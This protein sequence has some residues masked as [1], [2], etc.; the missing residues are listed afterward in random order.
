MPRYCYRNMP[1][2]WRDCEQWPVADLTNAGEAAIERFQRM[3]RGLR[4]YLQKGQLRLAATEAGCSS[5]VL[6]DVL[7]RCLLVGEDMKPIG[8]IGAVEGVRL[9]PYTRKKPTEGADPRGKS[10]SFEQFLMDN[11]K[12]KELLH[13]LIESG[14]VD[15]GPKSS[16]PTRRGVA[17]RF[18][19]KCFALGMTENDY[20]FNTKDRGRRSIERYVARRIAEDA[21]TTS[22]WLGADAA[23]K[24]RLGTGKHSFPLAVAPFDVI[25]MDTHVCDC[26]GT[27]C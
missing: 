18:R 3:A 5:S 22:T 20:P 25:C 11:P 2:D 10:G 19:T 8:W 16:K 4:H 21:T 17:S 7:N 14:G 26:I 27:V 9:T 13:G 1:P 23:K 24:R 12:K 6:L 15:E